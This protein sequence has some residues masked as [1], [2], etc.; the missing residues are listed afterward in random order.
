MR[1]LVAAAVLLSAC[2]GPPPPR[3]PRVVVIGPISTAPAAHVP[4]LDE[5]VAAA[6][7]D[8]AEDELLAEHHAP[9]DGE[10]RLHLV[11]EHGRCYRVWVGADR[12]INAHLEDEHGH[13]VARGPDWLTEVCPRWTGSFALVVTPREDAR[14]LAVLISAHPAP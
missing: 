7:A 12:A 3:P 13:S 10:A 11:F 5:R 14:S 4:S 1:A 2:G 8:L 9:L 6:R